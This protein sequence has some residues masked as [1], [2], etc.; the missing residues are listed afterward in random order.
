[1]QIVV[2]K[3]NTRVIGLR[4]QA[5][6]LDAPDIATSPKGHTLEFGKPPQG[7]LITLDWVKDAIW[8]IPGV[9]D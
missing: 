2:A 1:M 8:R 6:G 7:R 3:V 5:G 9:A 4:S